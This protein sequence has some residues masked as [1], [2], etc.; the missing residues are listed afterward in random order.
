MILAHSMNFGLCKLAAAMVTHSF[1]ELMC[2]ARLYIEA[3]NNVCASATVLGVQGA[4]PKARLRHS[5]ETAAT[6]G[7]FFSKGRPTAPSTVST[8]PAGLC[9][10]GNVGTGLIQS[11]PGESKKTLDWM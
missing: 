9:H 3:E 1:R 5:G 4:S 8:C 6:N 10:S 7:Q 11:C 2:I